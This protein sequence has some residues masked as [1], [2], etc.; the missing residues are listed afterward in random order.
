MRNKLLKIDLTMYSDKK[1]Y[2]PPLEKCLGTPMI[3]LVV[4]IILNTQKSSLLIKV[5][6]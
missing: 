6:T 1:K 5:R 4:F 3:K 2:C